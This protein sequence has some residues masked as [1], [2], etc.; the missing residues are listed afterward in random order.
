MR[1]RSTRRS[2]LK[3][4]TAGAAAFGL[5]ASAARG[6]Q[7]R[8]ETRSY[9]IS[10]AS[11]SL[12]R[13]IGTGVG[14]IAMVDLPRLVREEF[15]LGAIELVNWMLASSEKSY[16]DSYVKAAADH[17]VEILLIMV[18]RAGSVGAEG[19]RAREDA[20]DRHSHW[21][22]IAGDMGCHSIRMNWAGAPRNVMAEPETL[23]A[24][25]ERSVAPLR[26]LCD[27][28]DKKNINVIIENHGGPSSF[29][30]ALEA[31]VKAVDHERFGTLPDFG[32]FPPRVGSYGGPTEVDKYAGIDTM[33]KYAKA[34]SA[35]CYDFDDE[36]GLETT[37]DFE[38]L[39]Q[40]VADKHGYRGYIGIEYEGSRLSEF[41][42]VRRC[43]TLLE[44]LRDEG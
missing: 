38:R 12:H 44:K 26:K 15:G 11:Y 36:T 14:K 4:A 40:I 6:A 28:G 3:R 39:I 30:E 37:L 27:Y 25:T 32:N 33:M 29:P 9:S 16:I 5:S 21:I 1:G 35:K 17:D 2:F 34:V 18:D 31:L 43:K 13:A 19:E 42:G 22:D 8:A 20:V 7:V 10:L 24:F 41:E 23:Q